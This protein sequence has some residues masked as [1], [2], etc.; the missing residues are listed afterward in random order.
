MKDRL[1]HDLTA[2]IRSRDD[3]EL[4][5]LRQALAA[6]SVAEK[7]GEQLAVLPDSAVLAVLATEARKHH[8]SADAFVTA[9][10][11]ERVERERAEAAVIERY[12]P[13]A[14]TDEE[15][16]A[17]V[18]RAVD[19]AAADGATG[20]RAMGRVIAAVREQAGPGADGARIAA[21][22]KSALAG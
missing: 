7:A 13:A 12:L 18:G 9:G 14:L 22:V 5:A 19:D 6:I 15:L 11:S 8:E 21:L 16:A 3:V 1:Q 2:A 10:R 20:M 4:S 17:L